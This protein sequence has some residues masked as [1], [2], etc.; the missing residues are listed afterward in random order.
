MV[1]EH[2]RDQIGATVMPKLH[3]L[4]RLCPECL[5]STLRRGMCTRCCTDYVHAIRR[6]REAERRLPLMDW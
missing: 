6:R 1:H 4:S 2:H 3:D 5:A